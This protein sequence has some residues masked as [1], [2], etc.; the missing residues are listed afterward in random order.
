MPQTQQKLVIDSGAPPSGWI[1]YITKLPL[2]KLE[3]V[4]SNNNKIIEEDDDTLKKPNTN[5][6]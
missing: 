1:D 2:A 5:K 6:K 4:K 3:R